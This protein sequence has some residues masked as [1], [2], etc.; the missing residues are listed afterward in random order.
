MCHSVGVSRTCSDPRVTLAELRSISKHLSSQSGLPP[1]RRASVLA[2]SRHELAQQVP[3]CQRFRHVVV[4]AMFQRPNLLFAGTYAQTRTR[5]RIPLQPPRMPSSTS[6]P[7]MS[8]KPRVQND[9]VGPG[10][11]DLLKRRP[12]GCRSLN[13]VITRAQVDHQSMQQGASSSTTRMVVIAT[14]LARPEQR[15]PS[16]SLLPAYPRHQ[17]ARR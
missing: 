15:S 6:M 17:F 4:G 7:S 11:C 1:F 2:A 14:P 16:S 3:P 5:I 9:Q 12:T 8:G 13:L 10:A